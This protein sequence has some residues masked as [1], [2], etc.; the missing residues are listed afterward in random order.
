MTYDVSLSKQL[1]LGGR[2][3][4]AIEVNA[5]NVF[6]RANFAIPTTN[7]GSAFF[8]QVTATAPGTTPRQ[9]QFGARLT[10]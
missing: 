4:L 2:V 10:F 1:T 6:N 5:F 8:G 7:L 9:L 3:R